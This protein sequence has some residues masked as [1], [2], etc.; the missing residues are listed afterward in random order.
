MIVLDTETTGVNPSTDQVI[1]ICLSVNG[2]S[3]A[4]RVRPTIPIPA[5][6][7]AVHHITDADVADCPPFATIAPEIVALISAEDVVAG[8]NLK[9]DLDMLQAEMVRAKLPP[10]DFSAKQL[11]CALRLWHHVEPRTLAAAHQKFCGEPLVNAHQATADVA[12]TERVL[13]AMRAAFG[14]ADKTW[15]ELAAIANPFA[16]R[17]A[18]LGPSLHVQWDDKGEVIFGFGKNKGQRVDQTDAGFLRWILDKDFPPHVKKIC[19][20]ALE[21]RLHF[22]EW[23]AQYYPRASAPGAPQEEMSL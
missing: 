6:S 4:W 16:G 13:V 17:E 12:A 18:W 11:V 22:K 1:E 15:P 23:I 2:T 21:R 14:M 19:S 7:T 9:F 10:I 8:F 20:V 5:A 3:K